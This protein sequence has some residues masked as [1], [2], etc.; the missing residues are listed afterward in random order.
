[1]KMWKFAHSSSKYHFL[2]FVC[3][4][5][6]LLAACGSHLEE[7]LRE[8]KGA[9]AAPAPNKNTSSLPTSQPK[10]QSSDANGQPRSKLVVREP[11][12]TP[13]ATASCLAPAVQQVDAATGKCQ[14]GLELGN[15]VSPKTGAMVSIL[16]ASLTEGCQKHQPTT[17]VSLCISNAGGTVIGGGLL[18]ARDA[19]Q[20]NIVYCTGTLSSIRVQNSVEIPVS[21]DPALDLN[22][23]RTALTINP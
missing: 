23:F 16:F 12:E 1:M 17:P 8:E 15:R 19:V 2:K 7:D 9:T 10:A 3:L 5:V 11:A 14:I 21:P 22:T 18:C 6:T 4:H 20:E 13:V